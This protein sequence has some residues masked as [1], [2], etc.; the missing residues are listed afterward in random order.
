VKTLSLIKMPKLRLS[1]WLHPQSRSETKTAEQKKANRRS[2]SALSSV[3]PFK[4][5][6]SSLNGKATPSL[7][8]MKA[9]S[10]PSRMAVLAQTI[11]QETEK[12]EKYMKDNKLPMPSFDAESLGDFPKLPED[13]A[14]SRMDIIFATREL[15]DLVVGPREGLRWGVWGVSTGKP[16]RKLYPFTV[17]TAC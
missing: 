16:A 14:K 17:R 3:S 11:A 1:S 6:D 7:P 9:A 4:T 5:K 13:M 2:F 10:T 8:D 15:R 12:L